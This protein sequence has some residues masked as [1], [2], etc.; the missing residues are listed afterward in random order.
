MVSVDPGSI[1]TSI[2]KGGDH[3]H[4]PGTAVSPPDESTPC[5]ASACHFT[6]GEATGKLG[7][8]RGSGMNPLLNGRI[9]EGTEY[10]NPRKK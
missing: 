8:T 5:V 1:A 2:C 4:L 10:R 3:C 9:V 6:L 7:A